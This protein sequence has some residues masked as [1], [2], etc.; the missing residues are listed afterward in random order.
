MEQ[1][2]PLKAFRENQ[3]PPL[4]QEELGAMLGVSKAA[5]SRW[6]SG[7]RKVELELLPR[8]VSKTG[9]AARVLRPDLADVL[10]YQHTDPVSSPAQD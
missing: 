1:I 3:H 4:T 5:V 2:H 8:I 10:D 9:I 7:A 6:E